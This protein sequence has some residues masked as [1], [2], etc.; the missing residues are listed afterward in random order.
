V[1]RIIEL[2]VAKA[3][4]EIRLDPKYRMCQLFVKWGYTPLGLI[5]IHASRYG[6]LVE[7]KT[8]H[9]IVIEQ[10]GWEIWT[11]RITGTLE[12]IGSTDYSNHLPISVLVCTRD[13][14]D[15]LKKCLDS[16]SNLDYPAYEV[17]V[18]D[19]AS[20]DTSIRKIV[21][22]KGFRYVREETPG[23]NWARNRAF[24]EA[25][26]DIV[27]YIDD[28]AIASPGWLH[29]F[30]YGFSNPEI[31]AVTGM[32]LP[33]ELKTSA[34]IDFE[35]YGGMNKGFVAKTI[36]KSELNPESLLWAS[37]WGVGA[38]MGFRR[39][40]LNRLGGFD[41]A[42]DVGTATRGGGDIEFFYRTVAAGHS[43][44]YE[45]AAY[46]YHVHRRY[47]PTLLQQISDNG[48]SFPAYLL[49][50]ARK[51]KDQKWNV[52]RFGTR[53]WLWNWLVKRGIKALVKRD[54]MTWKFVVAEL[55]GT[56]GAYRD[57]KLAQRT[58][59]EYEVNS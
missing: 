25:K 5:Q 56:S 6:R 13:R 47:R 50:V 57:Y 9:S 51:H 21:E 41:P 10:L 31:M 30:A 18:V 23:L 55:R 52:V 54:H 1:E 40:L 7:Q 35:S 4:P 42:L 36:R 39:E 46:I 20:Q 58:A 15:Y 22:S 49:T 27:A 59:L 32:V 26:Y 33:A 43:L 8:V 37:Q 3:L 24:H 44:R 45:P 34:Q 2:D 14:P 53:Q 48:H 12:H 16:L 17:V 19:N 38:N 11:R 29:G 28:D